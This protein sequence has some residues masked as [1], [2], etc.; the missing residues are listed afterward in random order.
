[1]TY[2]IA[3]GDDIQSEH[4]KSCGCKRVKHLIS[5]NMTHGESRTRLYSIW[6][7]MKNRCYNPK[8]G[9]Y[10]TYGGRGIKVC[11]SWHRYAIF[12][13]WAIEHGYGPELTIDRIDNDGDYSP[14]NCRWLTRAENISKMHHD[15]KL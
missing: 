14:T 11:A 6:C 8:V 7:N 4:T 2:F 3:S 13:E 9:S 1:M 12:R 10:S 5:M 15:R